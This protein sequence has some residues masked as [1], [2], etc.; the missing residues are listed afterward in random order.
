M[1]SVFKAR[2]HPGLLPQ[3]KE[4]HGDVFGFAKMS[5]RLIQVIAAY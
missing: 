1:E 3:E 5:S 2:P 4:Q